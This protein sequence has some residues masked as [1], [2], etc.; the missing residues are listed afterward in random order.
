MYFWCRF[1]DQ[2]AL[3]NADLTDQDREAMQARLEKLHRNWKKDQDYLSPLTVEKLS[4][5]H[6]AMIVIPPRGREVGYVPIGTR[7]AGK[8]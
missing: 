2:P 6:P 8:E 1:A 4:E 5:V 7:P 3:L